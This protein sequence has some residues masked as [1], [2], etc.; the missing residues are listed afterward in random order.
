M[1]P[2]FS[3]VYCFSINCQI[4]KAEDIKIDRIPPPSSPSP[5]PITQS[6]SRSA[7]PNVKTLSSSMWSSALPLVNCFCIFAHV[8]H[9][10][11]PCKNLSQ[12]TEFPQKHLLPQEWKLCPQA[13]CKWGNNFGKHCLIHNKTMFLLLLWH[14]LISIKQ[15][16]SKVEPVLHTITIC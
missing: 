5:S 13:F 15:T 16:W 8:Q 6:G 7:L 9:L 4:P 11:P 12:Q 2:H 10:L 3:S 1:D 14:C